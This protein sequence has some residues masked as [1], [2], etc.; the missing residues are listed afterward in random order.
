MVVPQFRRLRPLQTGFLGDGGIGPGKSCD[1]AKERTVRDSLA[2]PYRE[3][4]Q[5]GG[6]KKDR[7]PEGI[8]IGE[9]AY[10]V[11][12]AQAGGDDIS[13]GTVSLGQICSL[14][15]PVHRARLR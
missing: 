14:D 1:P 13:A 10:A 3:A 12:S 4:T 9:T 8:I 5:K 2:D 15:E 6:M 11:E 7:Q